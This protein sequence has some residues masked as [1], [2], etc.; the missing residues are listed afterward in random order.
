MDQLHLLF[1]TKQTMPRGRFINNETKVRDMDICNYKLKNAALK[2]IIYRLKMKVNLDS[3]H[4]EYI[5][6][7]LKRKREPLQGCKPSQ[8]L[9]LPTEKSPFS[10]WGND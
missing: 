8:V 4:D 9:V 1:L 6:N 2:I 5:K 3:F 7:I 10:V